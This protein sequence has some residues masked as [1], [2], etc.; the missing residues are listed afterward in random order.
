MHSARELRLRSIPF[1]GGLE[2]DVGGSVVHHSE[3]AHPK[4]VAQPG[5]EPEFDEAHRSCGDGNGREPYQ[6]KG[7]YCRQA[8]LDL[9]AAKETF[10]SEIEEVDERHCL[11]W[12]KDATWQARH[13]DNG[14][15]A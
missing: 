4:V 1:L 2:G 10:R 13:L 11:P 5:H 8:D 12:S 9:Q 15:K 7:R 14:G 3:G 6:G